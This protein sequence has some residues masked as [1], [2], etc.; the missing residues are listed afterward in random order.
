MNTNRHVHW[1]NSGAFATIALAAICQEFGDIRDQTKEIKWIFAGVLI[2]LTFSGL[3]IFGNMILRD[4]FV[5]TV[6]EGGMVSFRNLSAFNVRGSDRTILL[7]LMEYCNQAA[8][9]LAM[10]CAVFPAIMN[11][12]NNMAITES[13][14][15]QRVSSPNIYFF[16]WG[17]LMMSLFALSGFLREQFMNKSEAAEE[18]PCAFKFNSWVTLAM[19]SFVVMFAASRQFKAM[20]CTSDQEGDAEKICRRTAF[21]LSLGAISGIFA[22]LYTV[23]ELF[24]K[25]PMFVESFFSVLALAAWCFGVGWITFGNEK[26]PAPVIGN[27]YFFTWASFAATLG[28]TSSSLFELYS[29]LCKCEEVENLPVQQKKE[30][31]DKEGLEDVEMEAEKKG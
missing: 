6:L 10:W 14:G 15:M 11:P 9:T 26:S 24:L 29:E 28:L 25:T 8:M 16:S 21:A 7:F 30:I 2:A 5:G 31:E 17:A 1:F 4:K 19:T 20:N 27:L 12:D 18:K 3:A 22:S 13:F 23:A